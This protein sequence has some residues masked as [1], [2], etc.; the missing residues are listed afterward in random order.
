MN[1]K[2]RLPGGKE[3]M[4]KCKGM[5]CIHE[6]YSKYYT[7]ANQLQQ[8]YWWYTE[9]LSNI[10]AQSRYAD[11]WGFMFVINEIFEFGYTFDELVE[12]TEFH[13]G[14]M[15]FNA[16]QNV[17]EDAQLELF[18]VRGMNK[19]DLIFKE[20]NSTTSTT[21]RF[22]FSSDEYYQMHRSSLNTMISQFNERFD[23]W[24]IYVSS[25]WITLK[26]N[27]LWATN[28]DLFIETIMENVTKTITDTKA[29][30]GYR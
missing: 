6:I 29:Y 1:Q 22:F 30:A 15:W 9:R 19:K 11:T 20:D 10:L 2:Y 14:M 27:K 4:E 28:Y 17:S 21:F 23:G 5:T 13:L 26:M 24:N 3:I 7:H 16:N 25:A 12:M 8:L 18:L